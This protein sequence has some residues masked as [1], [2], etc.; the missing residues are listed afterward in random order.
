MR[1]INLLFDLSATQPDKFT[2]RHGGGIY[3]EIVFKTILENGYCFDAFYDSNR[4]INPDIRFLCEKYQV[5]L[6]DLSSCS[7]LDIITNGK[8]SLIYSPIIGKILSEEIV[9]I[10][11]L[12]GLRRIEMPNDWMQL[13][14]GD[15][16]ILSLLHFFFRM[17]FPSYSRK[18]KQKKVLNTLSKSNVKFVTVS[19]HSKYS[20]LSTFP[21]I[22]VDSVRVFY[23]PNTS[24]Q[25]KCVN[26]FLCKNKYFMLVSGD[27]WEKNN[28]RALMALDE[29]FSEQEVFND[30]CA[31]I[32]GVQDLR[33]Y[34]YKFQNPEKI[35][36]K[37]YVED[38]V[39]K[40]LYAGCYALI[41]PSLNE[42][43]GY[44]PLE[45]MRYGKPV[46]ASAI[47]SIP[48]VCGDAAIYFNPFDY[49]EIKNRIL[50]LTDKGF[51]SECSEKA[52][53]RYKIISEKQEDDLNALIHWIVSE[54]KNSNNE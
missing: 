33:F 46:I 49:R 44:P 18:H 47:T 48:E 14:Y 24:T 30:Y 45:A 22:D 53:I 1:K 21:E 29:L 23:S 7:I 52:C 13:R 9:Y 50:M 5:H 34:K 2:I 10:S 19:N 11:T 51:Y 36:C 6:H 25:T 15:N 37:G 8:Y 27:R 42:G 28:L 41:Y 39:L 4:W 12:H 17:T 32:T 26:P 43:F 31:I 3:G 35:I 54:C 38:D 16:N 40:S 20:I